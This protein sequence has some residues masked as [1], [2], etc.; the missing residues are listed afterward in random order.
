MRKPH[1]LQAKRFGRLI[2]VRRI[3]RRGNS[4]WVVKCR[5]G[6]TRV[7]LAYNLINGHT[8][9]CGCLARDNTIK[10][11]TRHGW[12]ARVGRRPLYNVWNS[13]LQ[14]CSN[15]KV[16]S[17]R[18]YGERGIRVVSKWRNFIAF[19]KW[20][21]RTGYARGK[22]LHRKNNDGPYAPSNCRWLSK[23]AHMRLHNVK[24]I[25]V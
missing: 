7:V 15:S 8:Q 6:H 10:R 22:C 3:M 12:A 5:C 14:R 23:P 9:S 16:K 25:L 4:R 19:Q 2:A 21:E 17:Y 13:M 11:S 24:R 18:R 1:D 20:A